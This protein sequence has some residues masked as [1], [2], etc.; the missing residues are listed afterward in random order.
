MYVDIDN[1][2]IRAD[3][4]VSIQAEMP[5]Q[6]TIYFPKVYRVFFDTSIFLKFIYIVIVFHFYHSCF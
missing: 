6:S 5:C 4:K 1:E 2:V 3:S